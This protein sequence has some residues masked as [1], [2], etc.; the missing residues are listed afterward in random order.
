M[1]ISF[2]N[3][4]C[5]Y[6][7]LKCNDYTNIM[8]RVESIL[9]QTYTNFEI[10]IYYNNI[11]DII[12]LTKHNKI[13]FYYNNLKEKNF[14]IYEILKTLSN[15][16]VIFLDN[17]TIFKNNM[18]LNTIRSKI[19][20]DLDIILWKNNNKQTKIPDISHNIIYN[21]C[22]NI[23]M[24]DKFFH[25]KNKG[26]IDEYLTSN[27]NNQ[28]IKYN[29][30]TYD[31]ELY[32]YI[33][34][35]L[36]NL[37]NK[38]LLEH[39]CSAGKNEKRIT[40]YCY[41]T[42]NIYIMQINYNIIG[43]FNCSFGLSENSRQ[44]YSSLNN[45]N[46]SVYAIKIYAEGH[47]CNS[48]FNA[49]YL[50]NNKNSN[51]INIFC[52]NW[53]EDIN[54][55]A[56]KLYNVTINKINTVLWAFETEKILY[57]SNIYE[58][59]FHKIYTISTFCENAMISSGIS[60]NK[61]VTL[62]IPST[63]H[64]NVSPPK[65]IDYNFNVGFI[66]DFHSSM[67]RKNIIDVI[68]VFNETLAYKKNCYLYIKYMN[69]VHH[70]SDYNKMRKKIDNSKYKNKIIEIGYILNKDNLNKLIMSF[71]IYISLHRSEG[72][73][74]TIMDSI[75]KG[76][77]TICTAYGGNTD[78]CNKFNSYLVD[79]EYTHIPETDVNYKHYSNLC[80]W[81]QPNLKTAKKY[82]LYIYNNYTL[83]YNS[84][85]KYNYYIKNK[86]NSI[87]LQNQILGS[88]VIYKQQSFQ[89]HKILFIIHF[90]S[91][92]NIINEYLKKISKLTFNIN[93]NI[94]IGINNT[95]LVTQLEKNLY[96]KKMINN[97]EVIQ[98]ENYGCDTVGY[99]HMFKFCKNIE[100]YSFVY[101]LHTKSRDHLRALLS[102]D[103]LKI[104]TLK[105]IC[106]YKEILQNIGIISACNT[107]VPVFNNNK[108]IKELN[109]ICNISNEFFNIYNDESTLFYKQ[110]FD[111]TTYK[112]NYIDMI[113]VD[114]KY[115]HWI[116]YGKKEKRICDY[117]LNEI[118]KYN[119][120]YPLFNAGN[121]IIINPKIITYIKPYINKIIDK[122]SGEIGKPNDTNNPTYTHAL[123]RMP[124]I[125]CN[126]LKMNMYE[127]KYDNIIPIRC[128]S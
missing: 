18:V 23:N 84:V 28:L 7:I 115:E 107:T 80:K 79:Y 108:T 57:I 36:K 6:I 98:Y 123:E 42:D 62:F 41:V 121:I 3:N 69:S 127:I 114:N 54:I 70:K 118:L 125:I 83:C 103:L 82:L 5:I 19:S 88:T 74:L 43:Y 111:E 37:S 86:Y 31:L 122:C 77:P 17:N 15:G 12:H 60:K 71:N 35:D 90:G 81:A 105:M 113:D 65:D 63:R 51:N 94:I 61:I 50:S 49:N 53:N 21:S 46:S 116:N 25:F 1:K 66:F 104:G 119:H 30:N 29:N 95:L 68:D 2:L 10:L 102:N 56:T 52:I 16:W 45:S 39:A 85:N 33:H 110:N 8:S 76:I 38:Q 24:K 89:S 4:S 9:E 47:K 92:I 14:Y 64:K 87:F 120:D 26:Y 67:E 72:S 128:F 44:I 96:Y 101:C 99:L 34:E 22:F 59:Y 75:Y 91:N 126:E 106:N 20:S 117:G 124:G 40:K 13:K 48:N 55:I 97:I 100:Q 112:N 27:I 58:K 78:F 73:G 32:K 11:K 109:K 93:Y